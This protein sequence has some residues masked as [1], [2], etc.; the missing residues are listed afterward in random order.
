[1]CQ[2]HAIAV[3]RPRQLAGRS[4]L[5]LFSIPS[6]YSGPAPQWQNPQLPISEVWVVPT[7]LWVSDIWPVLVTQHHRG[8]IH[9]AVTL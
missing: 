8:S 2:D 7:G 6:P 1:M 9:Q 3:A 5:R 4:A